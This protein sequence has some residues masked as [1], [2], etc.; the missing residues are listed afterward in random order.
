MKAQVVIDIH[1]RQAS[2]TKRERA[3]QRAPRVAHLSRDTARF[4][5]TREREEHADQT[6]SQRLDESRRAQTRARRRFEVRPAPI[7]Y[8]EGDDDDGGKRQQLERRHQTENSGAEPETSHVHE[9]QGPDRRDCDPPLRAGRGGPEDDE[10]LRR[11]GRQCG[12]H[13]GIHH[14]ERLPAIEKC[15]P[16]SPRF[17]Q[18]DVGTSRVRE[19]RG[20]LPERQGSC[21]HNRAADDPQAERENRGCQGADQVRRRQEDADADGVADDQGARRPQTELTRRRL[22]RTLV[23]GHVRPDVGERRR[24][25]E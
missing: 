18:I 2:H 20:Q 4:P 25:H 12:R 11:A 24:E 5:E 22:P 1:E 23:V 7:A 14:E 6:E 17:A 16:L 9:S 10:V 15:N 13:G 19:S 3:G 21:Q 8:R